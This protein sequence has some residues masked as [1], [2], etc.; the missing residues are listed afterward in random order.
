MAI[1]FYRLLA[2]QVPFFP[3]QKIERLYI[4]L[5]RR[6]STQRGRKIL[7]LYSP[8]LSLHFDRESATVLIQSRIL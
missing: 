6:E 4:G 8:P 1:P 2:F 5:I 7:K 3:P